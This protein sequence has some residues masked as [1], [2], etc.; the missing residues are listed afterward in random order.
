MSTGNKNNPNFIEILQKQLAELPR[1][2]VTAL[3]SDEISHQIEEFLKR[4]DIQAEG[5]RTDIVM[6]LIGIESYEKF[7][8]VV[9]DAYEVSKDEAYKLLDFV[10]ED[11][12]NNIVEMISSLPADAAATKM[13]VPPPPPAPSAGYGGTSDPYREPTNN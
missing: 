9:M 4:E 1:K 10:N 13:A 3:L 11:L 7:S 2:Y 8:Q 5:V 12:Y 6:L